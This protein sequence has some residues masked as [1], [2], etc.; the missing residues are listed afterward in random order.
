MGVLSKNLRESVFQAAIQGKLSVKNE[1]DTPIEITIEEM[2]KNREVLYKTKKAKPTKGTN[3]LDN[4][5]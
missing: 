4:V 1:K 2:Q 3:E 5:E